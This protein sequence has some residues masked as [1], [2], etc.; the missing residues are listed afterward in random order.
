MNMISTVVDLIRHGE[1]VGGK[2]Y[3]GHTDDPLSETGWQQMRSAVADHRPWDVL[4]SSPLLRCKEFAQ[5]VAARHQLPLEEDARFKEIFFGPWEGK[6]GEQILAGEDEHRLKQFW[7]DPVNNMPPGAETMPDFE[8]RVL[9]A[10]Q[11]MLQRHRGKHILLV[12]HGGMM[13][14]IMA[15]ALGMPL[16]NLFRLNVGYAAISRIQ[17][18]GYPAGDFPRLRFHNGSL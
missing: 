14:V 10:W 7:S 8:A 3:R 17:V 18:D 2:R 6:T 4:V 15:H 16:D 9:A 1:P 11:E 12:G 5:Q 13:R